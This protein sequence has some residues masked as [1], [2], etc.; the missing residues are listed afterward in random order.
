MPGCSTNPKNP[1]PNPD[2]PDGFYKKKNNKGEDCCYKLRKTTNNKKKQEVVI[3]DEDIQIIQEVTNKKV[4]EKKQHFKNTP[5][6]HDVNP[7]SWVLPNQSTFINYL[8]STFIGYKKVIESSDKVECE[9][10]AEKMNLFPH[11]RFVRDYLQYKSPYRGLLVY[12]G[13]G[14]GKSCTSIATA[15]MLM[16][17]KKV[18]IML[19]AS[20]RPNYVNEIVKCGN[21]YYDKTKHYWE[22]VKGGE[23]HYVSKKTTK[24]NK[25][26]WL[27]DESKKSNYSTLTAE[28]KESLDLQIEDVIDYNYEILNYNGIDEDYIKNNLYNKKYFDN[29]VVIIDEAHNFT[30]GVS[31]DSK[32]VTM[33]YKL[34]MQATGLKIILLTGTPIINKPFEVAFTINLIKGYE[35]QHI[36]EFTKVNE[37][38]ISQIL[39]KIQF[40]D[41]YSVE[42][43][44]QKV[45]IKIS[46]IPNSFVKTNSNSIKWSDLE[47]YEE[48]MIKFIVDK[49]EE[50]NVNLLNKEVAK[51]TPLPNK[52][53][54]F[55]KFF[56]DEG[57][58]GRMINSELFMRRIMGSVSHF[59]NDDPRL[60]PTSEI[61]DE[62]MFMSD[63]QFEKYV[64]ARSEEKKLESNRKK[65]SN[66]FDTPSVYKTYSRAICN[67]VFPEGIDRPKPK[68]VDIDDKSKKDEEYER[69]KKAALNSLTDKHLKE[70]LKIYSP[71]FLRMVNNIEKSPGT[72]LI[73]SQFDDVEGIELISRV[74]KNVLKYKELVLKRNKD[75]KQWDIQLP[76][77]NTP[78]FIKFRPDTN[79]TGKSKIEYTNIVLSIYNNEFD[80][81]PDNIRAKL[82][83]KSNLRGDVLKV[84]FISQSGAEG[85][86]LK[87]VRQVHIT[88]PYWNKNRIDQV[89]GRA[90]RTCSHIALPA[91]ERNFIVYTYTMKFTKEQLENK[92]NKPIVMRSDK[93]LT[94][95]ETIYQLANKKHKI[96]SQFLESMQKVAVD[97]PLNNAG[98][99]CFSFPVDLSS[100]SK[101]YTLDIAK[102]TLDNYAKQ[103]VIDIKKTIQ[104]IR[105]KHLNNRTFIYIPNT[106]ELFDNSLYINTG[107]LVNVGKME[108]LENNKFVVT[109]KQN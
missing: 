16:N 67:F 51:F 38:I 109:L 18:V 49:F 53:E 59:T 100:N 32:I 60:Y 34:L 37:T 102:D 97:C 61:V 103:N 72:V 52:E 68:D 14:V 12:H 55:N 21:T 24:R 42:I 40:V 86:S 82:R 11:Q 98:V 47:M 19:P 79:L 41:T 65:E 106:G 46:L 94:T 76:N 22:F 69:R 33:L 93:G 105:I 26:V 35:T 77:D 6:Q 23:V 44:K 20:L 64:T 29:K 30:R 87:N 48:Q 2:C 39:S 17:Y 62:E 96:I 88:E 43:L 54:E 57:D 71:K 50:K 9:I 58:R 56:V 74:L 78:A 95:D 99:G 8:T 80:K 28:Q 90:N 4:D 27:I 91:S 5:V 81:V 1:I 89:I 15:E 84:L 7:K 85:I 3:E 13:L 73:Y 107:V 63:Y 101:A 92:K 45:K 10:Q 75:T 66:L 108:R 70:D 25:G 104:K 83:N 31:N 36:L